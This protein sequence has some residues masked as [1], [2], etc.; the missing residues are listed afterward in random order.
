MDKT[1][2]PTIT[3]DVTTN[4]QHQ[5][6]RKHSKKQSG[7]K[8]LWRRYRQNPQA[9]IGLVILIVMTL[10]AIF[11]DVIAQGTDIHPA[12]D[13]QDFSRVRE[14]PSRDFPFGTDQFGRCVFSRV[15]HGTRNTLT[16]GLIALAIST[17]FGI[18]SGA[19]A[20]YYSGVIDN[21]VMRLLDVIIAIPPIVLAISL[22]L[23]FGRGL[24]NMVLAAG[25]AF[26][27]HYA[28]IVRGQVLSVREQEFI[29]A[30]HSSGA[31][32]LRIITKHVLPNC[33]A[34]IIIQISMGIA[35]M[36]IVISSLSFLGMGMF[37]PMPEWGTMLYQGSR[38]IPFGYWHMILFPG[39]AIALLIIS[40]NLVG[41]GLRDAFDPKLRSAGF[42]MRRL[43]GLKQILN[44]GE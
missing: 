24:I 19:I 41:D 12:Y 6:L 28:R 21:T 36:I 43:K 7:L 1:D 33:I 8:E 18:I 20:G 25:I 27:P 23:V 16:V 17:V 11:A 30:A 26:I 10:T 31:G 3:T 39:I 35:N 15:V 29:E 38:F 2:L 4:T 42:S 32:D 37:P 34:P 44:S 5:K 40:F 13:I 14:L 22:G 9:V